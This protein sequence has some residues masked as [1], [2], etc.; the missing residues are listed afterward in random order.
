[1]SELKSFL[2]KIKGFFKKRTPEQKILNRLH[3]QEIMGLRFKI[4]MSKSGPFYTAYH[5]DSYYAF[6]AYPEFDEL[7]KR[8]TAENAVNNGGDIP[9]L[10]SFVLNCRQVID[11]G[12][13]GDFAELGVWRG[14][15]AEK[16]GYSILLKALQRPI[17]QA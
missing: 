12:I 10:W 8:F 9:R 2:V 4:G 13:Q 5:P 1:M 6:R 15:T 17:L 7:F 16:H 3:V 11:E 14:N